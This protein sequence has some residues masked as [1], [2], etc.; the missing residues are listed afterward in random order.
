MLVVATGCGKQAKN[1]KILIIL[2]GAGFN[3]FATDNAEYKIDYSIC[4]LQNQDIEEQVYSL[5]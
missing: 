1:R 5:I 2:K 3:S 4:P